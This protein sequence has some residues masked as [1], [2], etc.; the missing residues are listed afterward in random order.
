[1]TPA[2]VIAAVLGY[3]AVMFVVAWVSGRRADNAGFFTGNRRTPWY[4]AAFAMIGA[5][6]SGVTFISVP[7]S[8]AADSFSYMQM[9]A[10]FTVGQLIVAF[11]L[12]PTFYRL[13]VVSL[14]EYL[15]D[16]F[17]IHSHRTGAWFFFISKM[18]GAALRVYVVCAVLQLLVFDHYG[19]PLWANAL[20]TMAFVWLYT[21]QGGVQSLIW[22]DT[23]KTVCLV[24][25]LVLSIVFI[26]DGLGLSARGVVQAV[27]DSPMSRIFFFDDPASDRYFWKMFAAG[28]V[29]LVA[30]TGLDQDMMQRNLSCATPRDS[31]KNIVLTAVSQIFVIFLFLVLGVLLYLY[32]GHTGLELPAKSDQVFSLVAVDGGLPPVVGI[33]F[34]VGLISSTYSAAGSALTALTTSFTVDILEGTRRYDERRLTRVRRRVHVGMAVLMGLLILCFEAFGND[35]VINL[36]YKVAS[37]TYGP[38]LGMFAFGMFTRCRVRDRWVPFAAV[39]APLLSASLQ[40]AARVWWSYHIGFELLIYNALFTMLGM[41]LLVRKK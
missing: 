2:A 40:Y 13:R 23:L 7:G 31:Q 20:V 26:A 8:V 25:S 36:V 37:Y 1:M 39:A 19:L 32:A 10:G 16:R 38:I 41:L 29:L 14:Y 5:A 6:M 3:I 30:M 27:S 35:S 21:Q 34:V 9:V 15:D 4:M 17:G 28:I 11:V 33:L 12:I 24:G 22:T 18:L